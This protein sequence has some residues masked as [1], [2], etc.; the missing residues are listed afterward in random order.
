[1]TDRLLAVGHSTCERHGYEVTDPGKPW[2]PSR[3]AEPTSH[4]TP[5]VSGA[6][7][8]R[9][10]VE[11]LTRDEL[12]P[13]VLVSRLRNNRGNERFSL[14]VVEDV[15]AARTIRT[16]LHDPPLVAAEDADGRRTFYA[17][18]DR[19]PLAG[20]G[21]AAVRTDSDEASLIWREEGDGDAPSLLLVDTGAAATA[22]R[23]GVDGAVVASLDGVDG[24]CRPDTAA[25]PYSYARDPTDKRFR[26]S[27][28]TGRTVGVYDGVAA[29]RANAYVPVPMPLV[30]EHVFDGIGSVRD[31]WAVLVVDDTDEDDPTASTV[32]TADGVVDL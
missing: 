32:V 10:A 12:T 2:L 30:P 31:E 21:Y 25:F 22:D 23:S 29:M 11:P 5:F 16:V 13:T 9:V 26:I 1:M 27:T 15:A 8:S 19:V 7:T 4:T 6:T 20:G 24:L 3:L 17:G 28:G 18:P 14:F